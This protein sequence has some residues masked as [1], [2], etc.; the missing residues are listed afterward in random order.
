MATDPM[1][2]VADVNDILL[3]SVGVS[4]KRFWEVA[5]GGDMV[6]LARSDV[7]RIVAELG[8]VTVAD[9]NNDSDCT[10]GADDC[11]VVCG[12]HH[13]EPCHLCGMRGFHRN[14]CSEIG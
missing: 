11:C 9:H 5:R 10:L 1:C 2:S 13:G 3:A 7:A 12:A 6:P 4:A 8:G 14:G